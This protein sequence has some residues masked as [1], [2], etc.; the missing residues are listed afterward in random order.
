MTVTAPHV[1]IDT[2][3]ADEMTGVAVEPYSHLAFF[4]SEGGADMGVAD[5]TK[6]T[7]PM[8]SYVHAFMPLLPDSTGWENI[9]DPHGIAVTTSTAGGHPVGFLVNYMY[10]WV[11]RIDLQKLL[12]LPT[13]TVSTS[14]KDV[15][16]ASPAVTFLDATT[17]P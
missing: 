17:K 1:V 6:T 7:A 14:E 15:T 8:S 16:D 11:A 4:E 9:L 12:S 5:L 3:Y 10:N 13:T 2:S